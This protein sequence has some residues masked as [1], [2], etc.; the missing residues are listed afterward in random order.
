MRRLLPFVLIAFSLQIS[1][2]GVK[3]ISGKTQ[4]PVF[5]QSDE[6]IPGVVIVNFK[7]DVT[8]TEGAMMTSS[9]D[10]NQLF[11]RSG[12]VS[13]R[14]VFKG[15]HPLTD[16]QRAAGSVDL[17]TVYYAEIPVMLDPRIVARELNLA[18]GV[19]Y[20]EPKYMNYLNDTPNDPGLPNQTSAFTRLN[21]FN[22]WTIAKGDSTVAIATVDG[23]TYWP[24]EDLIGNVSINAL[25][26]INHN[27]H[28]D[29]GPPPAG[30]EDGIDEDGNGFV[31]DVVGWNFA[32]NTNNPTGLPGTPGSAAH[33]TATASHFGARTNNGIGMAGSSWNCGLIPVNAASPTSDDG[34]QFGYEGIAYAF[35]RGAKVINC[36]WGRTGGFSL[37]EQSVITAATQAGALVVIAAGNGTNNNG[38]GKNNDLVADFPANYLNALAV[39]A[40]NSTSDARAS[41]SNYGLS[42]PVYAPGVN[43]WS[44]F[45]GGG[46]GNGGS[47]TSY[48]SPLTAG[49][50]GIL[51]SFHPTWTPRQIATQIR[52]TA[53]S[54]DAVNPSLSGKLGRGRVNFARAL[55]ESHPGIEIIS[56]TIVNTHGTTLYLPN[57]TIIVTVTVKNILFATANNLTFTATSSDASLS[58]LQGTAN[59]G[60]L[61]ADQQVTLAPLTFRVGTLTVAKDINIKL[62]WLSNTN[63]RDAYAYKVTVFPAVPQWETQV[64]ATQT[65]LFSV[66]VVNANVVWACGGNG[67]ATAPA[68]IRT[69]D[70][71]SNWSLVTG[72]ITG[73][74]LYCI[75]AVDADHAWVGTG[76]L[77]ATPGK[78]FATTN[79]GTTWTL[80]S[81]PGTQTPFMDG[82]VFLDANNGYA[83]GDPPGSGNNQFVVLKTTDGGT[84]WAHTAVNPTGGSAE[85][86]WNNSFSVTDINHLWFGTNLSKIWRST[87]GGGTW[88]SSATSGVNSYA[89]SFKDNNNGMIGFDTGILQRSTNGGVSWTTIASPATLVIGLSY[90]PNSTAAWFA[91][92]TNPYRTTNDGN[93]WTQQTLS[94]F[95]GTIQHLNFADT[96]RGWAV[97]S[98][99]EVLHYRPAGTVGVDLPGKGVPSSYSLEQNYPNPFNPTTQVRF[100][101][102]EGGFVS[103]KVYDLLGRQVATLAEGEMKSGS[104]TVSFDGSRLSSGMYF[105][106]LRSGSFTATKKLV[107]MK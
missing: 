106:V 22:G 46:Y 63:D 59:A 37:F 89:V 23:G 43:I 52:V 21:A 38:I 33:G 101:I 71:G 68:V 69:T 77:G 1:A 62:A 91:S 18:D 40:T 107:L 15:F 84:T 90:L 96:S 50:A 100:E 13:L 49:L 34:I 78:I 73:A 36:S 26:D 42:I 80:Q 53:D 5:S 81:Y 25:E 83:M 39:G 88:A 57:D 10:I 98:N 104:H 8:V 28:F 105:Y 56:T 16:R 2:G 30:D 87:D 103:L 4:L 70:G 97:S 6:V 85:A 29:P 51:K 94:P 44:A 41:F 32:N 47:G 35:G 19:D 9:Q 3:K 54:I 14:R 74:D 58:V 76:N 82:V 17:S 102:G 86:G 79:G 31:D 72:N 24:H 66:K 67:S 60:N 65:S 61:A 55:S 11:S 92:G 93:T 75:A 45:N 95:T 7:P 12:V 20:A 99:G 64:S 48:A 27:G